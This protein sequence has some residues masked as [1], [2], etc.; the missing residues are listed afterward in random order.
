MD[1]TPRHL[2]KPDVEALLAAVAGPASSAFE[3]IAVVRHALRPALLR[4]LG[5]DHDATWASLVAAAATRG[6]WSGSRTRL[7]A[8][9]DTPDQMPDAEAVLDALWDLVTEL[10]EVRTIAPPPPAG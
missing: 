8:G 7:V 9:A 10:N 4:V 1:P 6:H 5:Q 2:R 3:E